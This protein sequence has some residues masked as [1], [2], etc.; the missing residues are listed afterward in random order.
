MKVT[1]EAIT[2]LPPVYFSGEASADTRTLVEDYFR[3]D[4]RI[5]AHRAQR[6]RTS[7]LLAIFPTLF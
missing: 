7:L 3:Q 5:R 2:D 6:R 1:R 4:P